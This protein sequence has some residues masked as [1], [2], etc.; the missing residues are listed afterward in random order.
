MLPSP[1]STTG[2]CVDALEPA[3]PHPNKP[4]PKPWGRQQGGHH[5]RPA[6]TPEEEVPDEGEVGVVLRAVAGILE[7]A[8]LVPRVGEV[9]PHH[10]EP[11]RREVDVEAAGVH[12]VEHLPG[13]GEEAG[14]YAAGRASFGGR[15]TAGDHTG[16]G[17]LPAVPPDGGDGLA[18]HG[19]ELG[20]R[21]LRRVPDGGAQA[22][23]CGECGGGGDEGKGSREA[24]SNALL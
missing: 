18:V 5:C 10:R 4:L 3:C 12:P 9:E 23:P 14:A 21:L 6:G 20:V 19:P 11:P 2:L 16:G 13:A 7:R 24:Q 17:D 15:R 22:V 1:R 8:G